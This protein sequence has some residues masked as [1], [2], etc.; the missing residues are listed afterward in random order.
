MKKKQSVPPQF[1][2]NNLM[3]DLRPV[4]GAAHNHQMGMGGLN[5]YTESMG[6][7]PRMNESLEN[8]LSENLRSEKES[9]GSDHQAGFAASSKVRR[10]VSNVASVS[11]QQVR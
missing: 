3:A 9:I 7:I 4:Q 5:S 8:M 2:Q 6:F 1:T 11:H 10:L